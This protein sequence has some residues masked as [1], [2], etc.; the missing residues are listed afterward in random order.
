[1]TAPPLDL[2]DEHTTDVTLRAPGA[3]PPAHRTATNEIT[4]AHS[5]VL[6]FQVEVRSGG[7]YDATR[8]TLTKVA[9]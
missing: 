7:S 2:V 3:N 4:T 9:S 8:L 5:S 6:S 1:V